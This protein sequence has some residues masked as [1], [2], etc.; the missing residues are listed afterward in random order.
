M[1]KKKRTKEEV[2]EDMKITHYG[3]MMSIKSEPRRVRNTLAF[4]AGFGYGLVASGEY[5]Q[6]E[7]GE[8]MAMMDDYLAG[9][10]D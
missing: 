10:K 8:F 6:E 3:M 4:C 2:F 9:K 5:T 7:A 1:S